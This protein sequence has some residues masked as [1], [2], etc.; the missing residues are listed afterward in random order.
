M[1]LKLQFTASVSNPP[2][3]ARPLSR[4]SHFLRPAIGSGSDIAAG[5]CDPNPICPTS[6][7]GSRLNNN[8]EKQRNPK[9]NTWNNSKLE[10]SRRKKG[11][12]QKEIGFMQNDQNWEWKPG[13][14]SKRWIPS[15]AFLLTMKLCY[16]TFSKWRHPQRRRQEV[17]GGS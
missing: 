3:D 7:C 10:S 5:K 1:K 8:Q 6:I 11:E 16:L 14:G 17:F 12:T 2:P 4:K 9:V 13:V 15:A